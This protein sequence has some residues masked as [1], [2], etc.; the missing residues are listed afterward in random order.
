MG[1]LRAIF[2]FVTTELLLQG[3]ELGVNEE[4]QGE[5]I[6]RYLQCRYTLVDSN[7]CENRTSF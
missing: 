6:S 4:L 1:H 2:F 7:H 3:V 5:R